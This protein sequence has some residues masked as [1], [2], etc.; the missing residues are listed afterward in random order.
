MPG[1]E[2]RI[3]QL[4]VKMLYRLSYRHCWI[5]VLSRFKL[6]QACII[7]IIIVIIFIAIIINLVLLCR[8]CMLL[9]IPRCSDLRLFG[10][11]RLLRLIGQ[12]Q[13]ASFVSLSQDFAM[14]FSRNV[15]VL[16][17]EVVE[18]THTHTHILKYMDIFQT[19]L[20]IPRKFLS[21]SV[22]DAGVISLPN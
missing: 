4:R 5:R 13:N 9:F 2:H 6:W 20:E 19:S 8:K 14:R 15:I 18:H 3:V 11:L 21:L 17:R 12:L 16:L 10:L 7:R 1:L 22:G